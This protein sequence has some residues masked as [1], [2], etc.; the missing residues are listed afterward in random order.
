MLNCF[1]PF[2]IIR[3]LKKVK[4]KKKDLFVI[5]SYN[6]EISSLEVRARK[7]YRVGLDQELCGIDLQETEM[8]ER[9]VRVLK[10]KI[11]L[12]SR[13]GAGSENFVHSE[14][15]FV[16]KTE[17]S[18]FDFLVVDNTKSPFMYYPW[19]LNC[20]IGLE[21]SR[22]SWIRDDADGTGCDGSL[23]GNSVVWGEEL[24]QKAGEDE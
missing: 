5:K 7:F 22:Q 17:R 11:P 2:F 3:E 9:G 10:E 14:V 13:C 20:W 24:A 12:Q 18:H 1:Q 23:G 4:I 15:S 8:F 6:K 21:E 16:C 19:R